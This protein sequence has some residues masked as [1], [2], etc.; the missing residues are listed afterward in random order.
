MPHLAFFAAPPDIVSVMAFVLGEC[1]VFEG[2]SLPGSSLRRFASPDEIQAAYEQQ[3]P[4]GLSLSLYSPTMGG[5]FVIERFPLNPG[6]FPGA[7]WREKISGWGLIQMEFPGLQG[8]KLRE[9]FAN[10]NSEKRARLWAKTYPKIPSV[11]AWDFQ[12][13]SRISRRINR[14][15]AGLAVRKDGAR[16][17]LP[18]ASAMV[19]RGDIIL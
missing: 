7:R 6:V 12:E 15:I 14:H 18:A 4:A 9:S 10:H 2:Y 8:R 13:V 16:P 3:G 17:I 19:D 11:A 1:Q 5:K